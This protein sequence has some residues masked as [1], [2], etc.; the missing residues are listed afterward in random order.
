M[1]P[2]KIASRVIGGCCLGG[3]VFFGFVAFGGTG[4]DRDSVLRL[5]SFAS[6]ASKLHEKKD[7]YVYDSFCLFCRSGDLLADFR[8]DAGVVRH[9]FLFPVLRASIL[10]PARLGNSSARPVI[11]H[12]QLE[13]IIAGTSRRLLR[14]CKF[15]WHTSPIINQKVM[16]LQPSIR[17]WY[18]F[19]HRT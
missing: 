17:R 7:R 8:A 19:P 9:E 1:R 15:D 5:R 6:A 12:G 14:L 4:S 2:G 18:A 11:R 13:Q 16:P 10:D 3:T